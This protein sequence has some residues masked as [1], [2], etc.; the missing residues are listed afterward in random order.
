MPWS[1]LRSD[2]LREFEHVA[3]DQGPRLLHR[4]RGRNCPVSIVTDP[5]RL[6]QILKNLLA[7]AFKFTEHGEVHIVSVAVAA[8]R[9]E[10]GYRVAR[11]TRRRC[12]PSRSPTPASASSDDQQQRIFEA[13]AQGDGT[14][15]RAVRRHRTG[16]V[17]QPGP[18]RP[19]RRR[20]HAGQHTGPGQH[21]HRV[22]APG[23][24]SAGPALGPAG[25]ALAAVGSGPT[26]SAVS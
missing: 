14:T 15:A 17:D 10:P 24:Q 21:V 20:D 12:W 4:S 9:L 11:I 8:S 1:R 22:P 18:G 23:V 16:S 19:A 3:E 6:S 26:G 25:G 7:N 2:L 5:Q 13:F